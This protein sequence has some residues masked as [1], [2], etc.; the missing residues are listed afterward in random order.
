MNIGDTLY[1][2]R[3]YYDDGLDEFEGYKYHYVLANDEDEAVQKLYEYNDRMVKL[4]FGGFWFMENE[5]P[6]IVAENVIY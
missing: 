4:G 2:F 3:V 5:R 1:R 6:A